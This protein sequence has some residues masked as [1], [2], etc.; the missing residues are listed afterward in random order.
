MTAFRFRPLRSVRGEEQLHG[1]RFDEGAKIL[2]LPLV[3][4]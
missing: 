3:T 1:S 2:H 4:L